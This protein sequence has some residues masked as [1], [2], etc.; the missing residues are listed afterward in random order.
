MLML[1]QAT[2]LVGLLATGVIYGTDVFSALVLRPALRD[3][4]DHELTRAAGRIHRYGD[5]RLPAPGIIGIIAALAAAVLTAIAGTPAAAWASGVAFVC[6]LG[7]LVLYMRIA[8]PINRVLRA[9]AESRTT[10]DDARELQR[11]WDSIITFRSILQ[12][13]AVAGLALALVLT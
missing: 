13:T 8:A 1:A 6:L 2:A 12:G 5:A 4:D 9:A 7:W 11:R 10:P 3:L